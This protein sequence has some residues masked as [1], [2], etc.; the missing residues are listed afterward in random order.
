MFAEETFPK[1]DLRAGYH[2]SPKFSLSKLEKFLN[3]MPPRSKVI[4]IA[5]LGSEGK[6]VYVVY[7]VEE[8]VCSI[9]L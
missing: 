4:S 5:H 2:V 8:K 9:K 1:P 6:T 3:S 7:K